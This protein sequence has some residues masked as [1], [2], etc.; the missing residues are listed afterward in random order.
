MKMNEEIIGKL[1]AL[2]LVLEYSDELHRPTAAVL[3]DAA[4]AVKELRAIKIKEME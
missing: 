1:H 3:K 4:A 2:Q